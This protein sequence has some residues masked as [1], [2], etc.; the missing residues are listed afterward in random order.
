METYAEP[1]Q[2]RPRLD[3]SAVLGRLALRGVKSLM[4][5]GGASVIASFL[6]SGLCDAVIVTV[7]PALFGQGLALSSGDGSERGFNLATLRNPTW[8]QLG[9]DVV[10]IGTLS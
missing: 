2:K 4:V 6:D 3:L 9:D 10:V 7:T 5:E 8:V 1:S